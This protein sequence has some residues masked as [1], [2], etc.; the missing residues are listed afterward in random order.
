[1]ALSARKGE[2]KEVYGADGGAT[3]RRAMVPAGETRRR[4]LG[5]KS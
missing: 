3:G 5:A 1:M 2:E 4:G